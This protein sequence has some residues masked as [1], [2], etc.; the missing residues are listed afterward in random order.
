QRDD[1]PAQPDAP[2]R[3]G[4]REKSERREEDPRGGTSPARGHGGAAGD[5]EREEREGPWVGEA[6]GRDVHHEACPCMS[7]YCSATAARRIGPSPEGAAPRH[8]RAPPA[9]AAPA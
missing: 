1:G 3:T 8:G 5:D 2:A 6:N 4:R 7:S 9:R